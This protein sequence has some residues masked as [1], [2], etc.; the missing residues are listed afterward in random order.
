MKKPL[1]NHISERIYMLYILSMLRLHAGVWTKVQT[2]SWTLKIEEW[3]LTSI[4]TIIVAQAN[5][6]SHK[7]VIIG[8]GIKTQQLMV[9]KQIHTYL[10][11]HRTTTC[12]KRMQMSLSHTTIT[13]KMFWSGT[14]VKS[15]VEARVSKLWSWWRE[16]WK[17]G[18]RR[19]KEG[20]W[21]W[22]RQKRDR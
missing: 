6:D 21:P 2:R 18:W 4:N 15:K 7:L 22:W 20:E 10:Q 16:G 12:S 13:S 14:K 19:R 1:D 8:A 11:L 9:R 5:I 3:W 17:E